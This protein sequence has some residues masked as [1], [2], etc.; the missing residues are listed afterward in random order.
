MLNTYNDFNKIAFRKVSRDRISEAI[1]L[2]KQ[3]NLPISEEDLT[4]ANLRRN[5]NSI[6]EKVFNHFIKV[7]Q[8]E[9]KFVVDE[10]SGP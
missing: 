10:L 9:N 7:M 8:D 4:K 2:G 6:K 1:D 5:A 3:L